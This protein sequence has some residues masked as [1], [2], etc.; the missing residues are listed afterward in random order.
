[1]YIKLNAEAHTCNHC[2]SGIAI[3]FTYSDCVF[4]DI[5]IQYTMLMPHFVICD[6][7]GSKIFDSIS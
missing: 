6:L 2:C 1:M 5:N 4:A 3:S 7:R